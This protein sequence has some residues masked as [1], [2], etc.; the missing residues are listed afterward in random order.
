MTGFEK[1]LVVATINSIVTVALYYIDKKF[2]VNR[3]VSNKIIQIVF[4][5]AFGLIAISGTEFGIDING[6]I[7]NIRDAA[8]LCAGLFFGGPAGIIAGLIGGIERWFSVYWGV[9]E[10]TRV[11]CTLGTIFAGFFGAFIKKYILEDRLPGLVQGFAIGLATEVVH[12]LLVFFTNINSATTA[13]SVVAACSPV[14]I[15]LVA[16][17]VAVP[18]CVITLLSNEKITTEISNKSITHKIQIGLFVTV[19]VAFVFSNIMETA[20]QSKLAFKSADQYIMQTV[21]DICKEVEGLSDEQEGCEKIIPAAIK[22]HHVGLYGFLIAIDGNGNVIGRT[23][24]MKD[25]KPRI[26]NDLASSMILLKEGKTYKSSFSGEKVYYAYK[27]CGNCYIAGIYPA[28]EADFNRNNSLMLTGLLEVAILAAVFIQIYL[29]ISSIIVKNIH[30]V[31]DNLKEI[32]DGKLDTVVDISSSTEFEMLSDGINTTVDSL[33][34][35]ISEAEARVDAELRV[36]KNIQ[37]SVLSKVFPED[38]RFELY[39]NMLPAKDVGGDFYDFFPIGEDKYAFLVA[40]VSGK[41]I[42]AAMFMMNAKTLIKGIAEN[43]ASPGVILTK[44]NET[45]CK[46]N[47]AEMFITAWLG[48]MDIESGEIVFANAGHNPPVLKNE[49]G[50][51]T[52]LKSRPGFVLAGMEG[53]VYKDN[54]IKL[55]PGQSLFLYTDGV[56]EATDINNKLFGEKRLIESLIE[57]GNMNTRYTCKIVKAAVDKFVG[58]APQFDDITMLAVKRK[59]EQDREGTLVTDASRESAEQVREFFDKFNETNN[60]SFKNATRIMVIVDEIY[61]NIF[62]YSG[63]TRAIVTA[64]L[65]DDKILLSF[66]DNGVLYNPLEKEDPDVTLSAEERSIGGLGIYMV[67]EMA[68]DVKYSRILGKNILDVVL[69]F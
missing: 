19:L 54:H 45:L 41:G 11:A 37:D 22:N 50:T 4:G 8:P 40:D 9:G 47:E 48:I 42:P 64:H 35:Y 53:I 25:V 58:E 62:N 46:N 16:L 30:K 5:I 36:A 67:K 51:F 33:K 32:S 39:A 18:S 27:K 66:Q 15:P 63:A 69:E 29:L 7:M 13:Y 55:N 38:N 3:N 14:M 26:L 68:Q 60:I 34:H 44:A 65:E 12:M 28:S 49:D 56:T 20:I 61:S 1:L 57:S 59:S 43:G 52:Y 2:L 31:N 10:L 17:T 23:E 21:N 6:A 24:D